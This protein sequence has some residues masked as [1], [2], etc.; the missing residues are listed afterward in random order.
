MEHRP[1]HVKVQSSNILAPVQ[2]PKEDSE[3]EKGEKDSKVM[4][5]QDKEAFKVVKFS[6]RNVE[7]G[8]VS[9]LLTF[10]KILR[11]ASEPKLQ[12][13]PEANVFKTPE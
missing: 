11:H 10:Q 9:K 4:S 5:E 2:V 1:K 7:G 8:G 12:P 3:F 6:R 13:D